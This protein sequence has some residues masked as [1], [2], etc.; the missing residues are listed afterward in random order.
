VETFLALRREKVLGISGG[1]LSRLFPVCM[2]RPKLIEFGVYGVDLAAG[3]LRKQGL[4]IKLQAQPFGI[5]AMLLERPGMIV[6]R[7]E[8]RQK[9]WPTDVFV[10]FDQGL[11]KAINKL[12]DALGDVAENPRFV[13]TVPKKGYR[14]IA[15]V[16]VLAGPELSETPPT[17]PKAPHKRPL[18]YLAVVAAATMVLF[19]AGLAYL[20]SQKLAAMN[21]LAVLPMVNTVGDPNLEYLGDGIT[22]SIINN[23]SQL[24]GLRVMA[25]STVF[26]YKGRDTDAREVGQRLGV[27]AVLMGRV[28]QIGDHLVIDTELINA[29][30]GSQ[31]WG[32]QYNRKVSDLLSVQDDIARQITSNLQLR[33]SGSQQRLLGR[34]HTEDSDAY[35]LYLRGRFYFNK[36]TDEGFLKAADYFQ[37]AI[38]RDPGYGLAYAGLA[39]CYGLLGWETYPPHE[40]FP[41]AK[42]MAEKALAIDSEM[43]EAHTSLAM[44]KA[45]YDWD[46]NGAEAEFRRAIELNPGYATAHHWY[47]IHLG[48]MG[49]LEDSRRELMRAL[50][51]DPLS[52]IINVNNAYPYH[53]NHQYDRAVDIYK[54]AIDMDP[55]FA[56]AH[57]DLML[58]YEQQGNHTAA[59]N[60]ASNFLRLT[61]DPTL[62]DEFQRAFK[63]SGYDAALHRWADVLVRQTGGRFMSPMKVAQLYARAGDREQAFVWLEKAF[64][65][66]SAPLVYLRVDPRYDRVRSDPRFA[67]LLERMKF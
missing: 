39:D 40:Y 50:D 27:R 7:E 35:Q 36:R 43:A 18:L 25:R 44:I 14:F 56:W 67:S 64:E 10:D 57:E 24:S 63:S 48:A 30:D 9:L 8:L 3:E 20:R 5:L 53:Y 38:D 15:P 19:L 58:A 4:R 60:E 32:E 21:S 22:E 45:L 34:H 1:T 42:Q 66:R 59:A 46:W 29:A 6:T 2:D 23:L 31:I 65:N 54:K 47:G 33:L 13:E 26:H 62:A 55:N 52:L 49:R 17:K 12:R 37:Q 41:K 11:N 16:K 61:G 28:S 51:L